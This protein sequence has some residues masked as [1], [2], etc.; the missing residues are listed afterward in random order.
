MILI[1][2]VKESPIKLIWETG[3]KDFGAV[4]AQFEEGAQIKLKE[5][6]LFNCSFGEPGNLQRVTGYVVYRIK[7]GFN[8]EIIAHEFGTTWNAKSQVIHSTPKGSTIRNLIGKM[9]DQVGTINAPGGQNSYI[10]DE[11]E[12]AFLYR[13][14]GITPIWRG[15]DGKINVC[16][17]PAFAI[18]S[19]ID[20]APAAMIGRTFEAS[21]ITKAGQVFRVS[22]GEGTITRVSEVFHTPGEAQEFVDVLALTDPKG[23]SIF[24]GRSGL[25]AGCVLTF[26]DGKKWRATKCRHEVR[27]EAWTIDAYLR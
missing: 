21:G 3:L 24:E 8:S 20:Y 26:P 11:S 6:D 22:S 18:N 9:G 23:F 2:G 1:D 5:G 15:P 4:I 13:V 16:D 25:R 12:I 17:P 7:K 19:Y 10:Q 27:H 14:A